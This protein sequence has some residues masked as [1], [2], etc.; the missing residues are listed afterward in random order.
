MAAWVDHFRSYEKSVQQLKPH[1]MESAFAAR[2]LAR[3][4]R[5]G[6]GHA[7]FVRGFE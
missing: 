7:C 3:I 4:C 1:S 2:V 6:R 5:S